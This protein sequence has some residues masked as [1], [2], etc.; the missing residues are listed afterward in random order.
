MGQLHEMVRVIDAAIERD[1]LDSFK[2]RGL[3][4]MKAGLFLAI[5]TPDTPDDPATLAALRAAAH[6]VLGEHLTF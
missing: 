3:I 1:G 2:T 5:I 4:G 6:E